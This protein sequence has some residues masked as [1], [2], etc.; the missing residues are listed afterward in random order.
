M[1]RKSP[2]RKFNKQ[3]KK[4]PKRSCWKASTKGGTSTLNIDRSK[5]LQRLLFT[6]LYSKRMTEEEKLKK[7]KEIVDKRIRHKKLIDLN[8][9][10][11]HKGMTAL[12]VASEEGYTKIVKYLVEKGT[13]INATNEEGSTALIEA[14]KYGNLDIV[15]F[16]VKKGANI[17]NEQGTIALINASFPP[18]NLD[19]VKFLVKNGVNVN[20]KNDE[21]VTV[22]MMAAEGFSQ[23]LDDNLE[24]VK[25]LVKKG[26]NVNAKDEDGATALMMASSNCHIEIVKFLVKNGADV[27]AKDED[28]IK[29][30]EYAKVGGCFPVAYYLLSLVWT[31]DQHNGIMYCI[32]AVEEE[33]VG[34]NV[35][36]YN[37]YNKGIKLIFSALRRMHGTQKKLLMKRVEMYIKR[38]EKLKKSKK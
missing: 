24:T 14:S 31:E 10:Y 1:R 28:G 23:A 32:E 26:A 29:A 22:L 15:K 34:H 11:G 27:N 9:R 18:N 20:A 21:D 19:I 38:M 16:L 33:R 6:T 17:K 37:L 12:L 13:N 4:S 3:S 35:K 36:A 7:I 8:E 30:Q 5:N 25:F 2:R